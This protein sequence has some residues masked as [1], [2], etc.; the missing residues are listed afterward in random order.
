MEKK[1]Q[2]EE[3]INFQN[4]IRNPLRWFGLVYPYFLTIIIIGG[5]F[6]IQ[7]MGVAHQNNI[8][9]VLADSANV[10][11]DI[12]P[13]KGGASKAVDIKQIAQPNNEMISKGKTLFQANCASCHGN[14]G[15][16]DGPAGMA[17]NPKPRNFHANQGWINGRKVSDMF[18]TLMKGIPNSGM[19]A[20]EYL[21]VQDRIDLISYVRTFAGD[22]P[23][24]TDQELAEMDKTY[25]LS[26]GSETASQ[27]PV[28]SAINRITAEALPKV[29]DVYGILAYI[30]SNPDEPGAQLFNRVS[31]NKIR[32]LSFLNTNNTWNAS[33]GD[34]IKTVS[35]SPIMNGFESNIV[36]LSGTE[37]NDLYQY[38]NK[39]YSKRSS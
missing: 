1:Q 28:S 23:K 20:F 25:S 2:I 35:S 9:P 22:F 36:N 16:G 5:Y 18:K 7:Y 21:P 12:K 24:P 6:Y 10:F 38:L 14:N 3:E 37:W 4:V 33:V 17:L 29:K 8:A 11:T 13:A 19:P 26:Q 32:S 34:F 30:N 27:I 31:N 15:A 39:L